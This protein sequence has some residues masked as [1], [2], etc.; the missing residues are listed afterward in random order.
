MLH[1][2]KNLKS[3][4]RDLRKNMTEA[5]KF[6]WSRIRG[7]QLNGHQFYRQ[8]IIGDFIV[9]FYCPRARLIIELD[10]GQHFA[11]EGKEKDRKR[12]NFMIET[13][14]TVLR[15]SDREVFENIEGVLEIIWK[16]SSLENLP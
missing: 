6:L 7:K 12:D 14:L 9:D 15:F 3:C 2:N 10:G 8:K 1:Y 11:A 16:T 13:G 4:S 5:E